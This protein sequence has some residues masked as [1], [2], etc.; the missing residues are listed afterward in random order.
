MEGS[1]VA[2]TK[3]WRSGLILKIVPLRSPT[4]RLRSASNAKPGGDA[5]AFDPQFRAALGRDAMNGAVIA[6]GDVQHAGRVHRQAGGVHHLG[7]ERLDLMSGRDFVERDRDFLPALPA[8]GHVDVSFGIHG[9]VSDRMQVVGNLQAEMDHKGVA[10]A[11]RWR[12]ARWRRRDL[13]APEPPDDFPRRSTAAL[14]FA[15][16]HARAGVI[17]RKSAAGNEDFSAGNGGVG[18]DSFDARFRVAFQCVRPL[19][20]WTFALRPQRRFSTREPRPG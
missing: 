20:C 11:V 2:N 4:K 7:H 12:L 3:I 1:S 17:G 15:K 14:G 9:G 10:V 16:H 13:P 5:H 19:G 6:A 8:E 18:C